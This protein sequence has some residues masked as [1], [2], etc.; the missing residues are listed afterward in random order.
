[1]EFK[2]LKELDTVVITKDISNLNLVKGDIGTI[3]HIYGGT[4][5]IEVEF[6]SGEGKTVGVETLEESDVR[7]MNNREI[8]HVREMQSA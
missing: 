6:V 7:P 2:V 5:G 4:E 8:L 1:M 3:V